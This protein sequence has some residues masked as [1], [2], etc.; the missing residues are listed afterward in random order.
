M[1]AGATREQSQRAAMNRNS[2]RAKDCQSMPLE[3]GLQ[4]RH[5]KIK[6]VLMVNRIELRVLDQIDGVG[7][8]QDNSATRFDQR[9]EAGH[10]IVCVWRMSEDIVAENQV[11]LFAD[12]RKLLRHLQTEKFADGFDSLF[13]SNLRD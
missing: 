8:F 5:R 10:E 9:F 1:R 6:N 11:S 7:K 12:R 13:A 3:Q 4:R 2:L